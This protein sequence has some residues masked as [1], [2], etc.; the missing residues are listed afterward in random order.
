M[1]TPRVEF[2][3]D[4]NYDNILS[5]SRHPWM[6]RI[7]RAMPASRIPGYI[8]KVEKKWRKDERRILAELSRTIG[9]PWPEKIIICYIAGR[10][11]PFSDPLTLH[12][13]RDYA[14]FRDTLTHELIHRLFAFGN[15]LDRARDAWR[16]IFRKYAKYSWNTKIHIPL[17][18][19][20]SHIL[21]KLYG[22]SRI[23]K[24]KKDLWHL[25]DYRNSWRVVE[26]EGY[27]N[28][29]KEFKKRI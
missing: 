4:F 16:Y 10:T 18:A 22:K 21:L 14:D 19:L 13:C 3:F 5:T 9:L 25:P 24:D 20:H 15:N 8:A 29:I 1:K 28:I 2:T 27:K 11:F 23:E 6:R 12:P 26:K 17:H 7:R